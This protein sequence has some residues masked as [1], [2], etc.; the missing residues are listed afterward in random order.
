MS[1]PDA[2]GSATAASSGSGSVALERPDGT[3]LLGDNLEL[4]RERIGD[5]TVDLAYLDPPFRTQT[6]QRAP[7][8]AG[9][10][11]FDDVW[12]W[13]DEAAT[14][15]EAM[16][17]AGGAAGRALRGLE[18]VVGRSPLLA[19]LTM[20][21]P[22]LVELRRVLTRSGSVY[23][24]CDG[25]ASHYLKVLLDAVFGTDCFLNNV[26]W[27]Y[28]LGGSSSR[29]WPRKHDDLLWYA[30]QAGAHHFEPA[31][32]PARSVR[33]RGQEKK[34]P[35]WWDI[36]SIN[37]MAGERVGYPTQKPLALLRRV[38]G[39]SSPAGGLVLDPF[40]GSGTTLVAAR[41]LGRRWIGIDREPAAIAIARTR[42]V[43]DGP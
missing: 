15:F 18:L 36:P 40:C 19:Y 33:M 11:A 20:V 1:E 31:M 9:D 35:D 5:G 14:S 8:G 27:L 29:Y 22:R 6:R 39:S 30:R 17:T 24:H 7:A 28:G 13:D 10:A 4:M 26:V 37:N 41:E 43:A 25:S 42:L 23:L 16:A 34:A 12:R 38:V 32:V 21:A 3:L 2:R